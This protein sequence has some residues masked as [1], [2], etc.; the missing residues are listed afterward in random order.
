LLKEFDKYKNVLKNKNFKNIY[1]GGGTPTIIGKDNFEKIFNK[2][3]SYLNKENVKEITIEVFPSNFDS[4]LFDY[5]QKY[6][7]RVSVG[8]QCFN[9]EILKD[10]NRNS[11]V[12]EIK[13]FLEKLKPYNFIKNFDI[14]YGLY[15]EKEDNY[16]KDLQ[17]II[18]FNPENITYQALHNSKKI[19]ESDDIF[20]Q[21]YLKKLKQLNINGR[22]FLEKN[23]YIQYTSEDFV[24]KNKKKFSYQ[25]DFLNN[26]NM[27]A[28]G[29]DSVSFMGRRYFLNNG[30][31][32]YTYYKL[33][34]YEL[35]I[36]RL[37]T[38]IRLLNLDF[39]EFPTNLQDF[40]LVFSESLDYLTKN[41]LI[42]IDDK[43][44]KITKKGLCYADLISQILTLNNFDYKRK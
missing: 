31:K 32:E 11:K 12:S 39:E 30:K 34:D 23:D 36:K 27:L 37:S 20:F 14:I 35:F 15:L 42:S 2:L 4:D 1:I 40:L 24:K 19:I 44:M 26:K 28:I 33:K 25:L 16:L 22:E 6:V 17:E 10:V 18:S 13:D 43:S 38:K 5:L 21:D 9:N 29:I 8:I 7:T 41:D 3:F